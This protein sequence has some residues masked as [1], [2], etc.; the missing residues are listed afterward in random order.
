MV[1]AEDVLIS[2]PATFSART[3]VAHGLSRSTL[4]RLKLKGELLELSRGVYRKA[5]APETAHLDLLAVSCRVPRA[6]VCL[7]SALALHELTDEVPAAVQFAVPRSTNL[8]VVRYPL[9]EF[10]R[11]DAET[12]DL[13]REEF[14]AAPGESV[15][16]YS[17]ARSVVDVMRLRH[18]IG[19]P[20]AL[21]ALRQY[22]ARRD[23]QPGLLASYAR[24][25]GVEGPVMGAIDVVLS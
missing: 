21:R 13:G 25:L 1:T 5:D 6:V 9:V 3:A 14:E 2:L 10:V 8:P 4:G 23:A 12:F 11:F 19:E 15:P 18:R 7:V 22:L 16:I 24:Q 17:A 20:M